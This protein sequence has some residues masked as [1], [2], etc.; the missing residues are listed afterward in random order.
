[1]VHTWAFSK[2]VQD[3]TKILEEGGA[4]MDK[5]VLGHVDASGLDPEYHAMLA[6]SGCFIEFDNF[7]SELQYGEWSVRDPTDAER[8]ASVVELVRKGF[9]SQILISQD[10]SFK[11][12]LKRY[13]G[14]GYDHI[15]KK[16]VPMLKKLV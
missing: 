3:I 2:Q 4:N 5:I 16:I 8:V 9:V 10:I 7:G 13:G 14:H 11:I 1:M 6:K 15:L 12:Y